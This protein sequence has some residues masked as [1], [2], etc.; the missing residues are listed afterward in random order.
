MYPTRRTAPASREKAYPPTTPPWSRRTRS[1]AA[2]PPRAPPPGGPRRRDGVEDRRQPM[3]EEVAS[4]QDRR[5]SDPS[6]GDRQD[7]QDRQRHGHRPGGFVGVLLDL[8]IHPGIAEEGEEDQ[9]EHVERRDPRGGGGHPPQDRAPVGG[10]ERLPQDLVLGEE[11]R[12]PRD[13][14]NRQGRGEHREERDGNVFPQSPH[15]PHVLLPREG[16]DHRAGAEEEERLEE[17]VGH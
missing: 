17:G 10:R 6:A 3:L 16:V 11:A 4:A 8:G 1:P 2:R 7:R 5:D 12:Q 14:R 13:P 15:L 9:P